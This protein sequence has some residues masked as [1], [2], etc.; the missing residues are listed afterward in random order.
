MYFNK[1]QD[2]KCDLKHPQTCESDNKT[3]TSPHLLTADL[4]YSRAKLS[5]C[6]PPEEEEEGAGTR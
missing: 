1:L 6:F 5:C 2:T 4:N 3:F